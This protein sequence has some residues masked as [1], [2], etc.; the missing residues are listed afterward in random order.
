MTI[1][2]VQQP[3]AKRKRGADLTGLVF[4]R[5]T[6]TGFAG[7]QVYGKNKVRTWTCQC[8]CGGTTVTTTQCL[9]TGRAKSC[10]CLQHEALA[11]AQTA[12]ALDLTG[13]RFGKLLVKSFV[14]SIEQNGRPYRTWRCACDCG[15]ET[16]LT[17]EVLRSGNTKSCG[18]LG[19]KK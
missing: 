6:V 18:C 5:L 11:G 8:E 10:G 13:K 15:K 1:K 9:D 7:S 16:E 3:A 14:D 17:T 12:K 4:G 19:G 2:D